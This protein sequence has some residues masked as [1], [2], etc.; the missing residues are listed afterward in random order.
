MTLRK[1]F[2]PFKLPID[3]TILTEGTFRIALS[4]MKRLLCAFDIA[5]TRHQIK[6]IKH[7]VLKIGKNCKFERD[8]NCNFF[9]GNASF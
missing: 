4:K 8:F 7:D 2:L 1:P 9:D 3:K 5:E 6:M